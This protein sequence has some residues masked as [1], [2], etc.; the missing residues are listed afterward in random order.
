VLE[1]VNDMQQ[2]YMTYHWGTSSN[3]QQDGSSVRVSGS[4]FHQYAVEWESGEI[5][6]Y[7]DGNLIKTHSGA[8][9]TDIA[10]QLYINTALGGSFPGSVGANTA[11]PQTML[12]DYVRVYKSQ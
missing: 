10:M 1:A 6:W 12:V 8:D 4:G 3:H 11:F 9:V 7:I 2:I 5:R